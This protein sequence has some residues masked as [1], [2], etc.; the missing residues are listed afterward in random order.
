[1]APNLF[2][3]GVF[4]SLVFLG[5]VLLLVVAIIGL[6]LRNRR[7]ARAASIAGLVV[8]VGGTAIA[9]IANAG[10]TAVALAQAVVFVGLFIASS[11]GKSKAPGDASS[12][13]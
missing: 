5:G 2:G 11:R 1:M 6:A 12:V 8:T 10:T 13:G 9:G 3:I 7:L 4:G